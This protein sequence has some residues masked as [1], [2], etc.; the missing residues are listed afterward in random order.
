[1]NLITNFTLNI[2]FLFQMTMHL[3]NATGKWKNKHSSCF[4]LY[5]WTLSEDMVINNE[6]YYSFDLDGSTGTFTL[7]VYDNMDLTG[8]PIA[9]LR[10]SMILDKTGGFTANSAMYFY[11]DESYLGT[12]VSYSPVPNLKDDL[13][14]GFTMGG[15][16]KYQKFQATVQSIVVAY[17]P[18]FI[19]EWTFCS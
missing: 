14:Y 17:E 9:R 1:M 13:V 8:D 19:V 5:E 2:F 6:Q 7:P 16:G 11:K 12:H 3:A 15:T 18:K 4:T 10:G